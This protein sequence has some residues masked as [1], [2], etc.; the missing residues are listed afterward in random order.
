MRREIRKKTAQQIVDTVRDISGHDINFIDSN[1]IIFA[2]TDQTRVGTFHEIGRQVVQ[3]GATI[4]VGTDDSFFGTHRGVNLPFI[5]RGEVIAA[6]G[7][8]GAPDEVRKFAYLAQR[9]TA[10]IMRE[11]ELDEQSSSE[12]ARRNYI[13]RSLIMGES[14][15]YD[16]YMDFIRKAQIDPN[17]EFR[18]IIVRINSR[19]DPSD[20]SVIESGIYQ[21]FDQTGAKLYTFIYPS[22]YIL[23][24]ESE[25][26]QKCDYI[27]RRLAKD[28]PDIL[29]IGIG[30]SDILSRQDR[31]Y[32]AAQIAL[33]SLMGE[34]N[35]AVFDRL[36]LEILLG[37][38]PDDAKQRFLE[39]T[40][41]VLSEQ[42]RVLLKTYFGCGMSLK[43]AGE[44]LFM[45]KNTLQYQLDRIF[46]ISG[47]NPRSFHDAVILYLGLKL[48]K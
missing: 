40:A 23:L 5:Y 47:Y 27:F 4:E 14:V 29:R 45:H 37:T 6:I 13:I 44:A 15:N 1:G 22:E 31:S 28:H 9:I 38:V 11:Q 20:F 39:K 18:T 42:D 19:S 3:T 33:A 25:R 41:S 30:S 35:L 32:H 12:S 2:S 10:I 17:S 16:F 26:Y 43:A 48:Q 36:D 46:R 7:I 21:A 24:T 8:T 34:N